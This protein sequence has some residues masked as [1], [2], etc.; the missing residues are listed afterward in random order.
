MAP[1]LGAQVDAWLRNGGI[2]VAASERAARALTADYHRHQRAEG[3]S[4]WQ[5]PNIHAWSGFANTAW[6]ARVNDGRMLLNSAQE[7]LVWAEIIAGE[8]HLSTALEAPRQRIAAIA[9]EAH[10]RLCSHAPAYLEK[11]NRAGWDLDAAA[12]SN[13]LSEFDNVCRE[14]SLLSQARAPLETIRRL[15]QDAAPRPSVLAVGFDR[16]LP[17]QRTLFDAWGMWRESAVHKPERETF[18]YSVADEDAEL[19]ACANWCMHFLAKRPDAHLL[20]LSQQISKR[21]GEF[22]RAF[23]RLNRTGAEPLFEFSLGIPLSHVPLAHTAQLLL[24]WLG[25]SVEEHELDWLSS[26]GLLAAD[27]AEAVAL[28]AYMRTLRRRGLARPQWTLEAFTNQS[29]GSTQLPPAWLRRIQQA[30]DLLARKMSLS[31]TALEWAAL[32]PEVLSAAALPGERPL[33]SIEFQAWRRW[34]EVL[35]TCGSL[36]FNGRRMAWTEFLSHLTRILDET[37]FAPESSD[38]PIQIAGPAES[39]GLTADAI[40]FLGAD[41]D[42]WPQSG[43]AHP[44]LPLHIQRAAGMPHAS[45]RHDWDLTES[46]TK[47]LLHSAPLIH[48]SYAARKAEAETR[49]SRLVAQLISS[50]QA[51]PAHLTPLP[52]GGPRTV[53]IADLNR[54]PSQLREI[55]GGSAILTSQSQCP[56]K[57]FAR[58]RLGAEGWDPAE[59]GLS[60]PQ[61]GLLLHAVLHTVWGGPPTGF[62]SLD[63]L[64]ACSDIES[65]VSHHVRNA[66]ADK[67]PEGIRDRM[68][69]RYLEL[70]A[71]RLTRV[72][73]EWLAYEATR[74][75]FSV[76]ETEST[77]AVEIAGLKLDLRIDRIDRLNDGSLLVI[78]YKTGDVTPSAW[79]L[80]RADDV[81]LPL[82]AGFG[83]NGPAGGLVFAKLRA[84]KH[85]IVGCVRDARATLFTKLSGNSSLV[86]KALTD[87][88]LADWKHSIEQLALDFIAGRAEVDP[89]DYPTTCERCELPALCRIHE[90]RASVELEDNGAE[91]VDV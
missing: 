47:R 81:Q 59:Y 87:E 66:F 9:V 35:D 58:A 28:P 68:P 36:G 76:A 69:R 62:R 67:L 51:L 33:S 3:L 64:L 14:N 41:E 17:I 84:G 30:R 71:T 75:P 21:R 38:P 19:S 60:A 12:F 5:A 72:I 8:E 31:R 29:T 37:L 10:E 1:A 88:Q 11:K 49:P 27:P 79:Q 16:I 74:L 15:E 45:P 2:V 40:W 44:L 18:F 89:R 83:L 65:F 61:R 24:Q 90:I 53:G 34:E 70:E 46:V 52:E 77:R 86:K 63:D 80:P 39:A 91:A 26:T 48:F 82:Y 57:A 20:V 32:V 42:S 23:L 22:E 56:F 78:D 43:A 50:P 73:T 55:R 85:E 54:I 25:G 6:G 4:A 7:Q 13:W